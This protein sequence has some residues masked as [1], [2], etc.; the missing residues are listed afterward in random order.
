M[1]IS[2]LSGTRGRSW[3]GISRHFSITGYQLGLDGGWERKERL[4]TG[5]VLGKTRYLNYSDGVWWIKDE[6]S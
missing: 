4:A 5:I 6:D 1:V 2:C 3:D